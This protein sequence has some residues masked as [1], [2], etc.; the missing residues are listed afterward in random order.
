MALEERLRFPAHEKQVEQ[1]L[2]L[3]D[4][5]AY[6]VA[7]PV[8]YGGVEEGRVKRWELGEFGLLLP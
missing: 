5:L 8:K 1:R 4:A 3:R 7:L 6:L 2:V